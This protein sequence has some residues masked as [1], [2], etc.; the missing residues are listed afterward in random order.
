ML[1]RSC[2]SENESGTRFCVQCA[3]PLPRACGR[4]RAPLPDDARFCPR[5]GHLVEEAAPAGES[6]VD[7]DGDSPLASGALAMERRQLTVLFCD[8]V[9]A[10]ELASRLDPED[11]REVVRAYHE[12]C[13]KVVA[14]FQ[15][16]IA[17]YL[18]DGL[19]VYFGYPQAHED[20]AV[21]AVHAALGFIGTLK[22]LNAR[23]QREWSVTLALRIGVH[24][25]TVVVG[26]MGGRDQ[27]ESLALGDT[28]NLA[29]RLQEVADAGSVVISGATGQLVQE[30]FDL[31][32]LGDHALK[33]VARSLPLFRVMRAHPVEG[34]IDVPHPSKSTPL[35][36]REQEIGLL[37][38]GWEQAAESH[39]NALLLSGEAGMGKSRL[40]Q[41]LR[42]RIADEPHL[43]FAARCSAYHQN[44]A[45]HS[46]IDLVQ[47]ASDFAP[48]DT[49]EEKLSK[50][51]RVLVPMDAIPLMASLLSIPL[52]S[53]YPPITLSPDAQRRKTL[54]ALVE[55][56]LALSEQQ[57]VVLVVEDLQ[58]SDPS[59]IEFLGMLLEQLPTAAL[60]TVL[61]FRREF[62]SPWLRRS[63]VMQ[64]SL[65]PLTR[66][67]TAKMVGAITGGKALPAEVLGQVVGKTDGVPLFVE[68]LTK[69]VVES[70]LVEERA[71][72]FELSGALPELA[73]PSTLK[74]SLMARLDRASPTKEVVQLGAVLGR[75]F[76]YEI[77]RA[78]SSG[79]EA[80]LR[81]DLMRLERAELILR[82]GVPPHSSYVFKHALIQETA[83]QSL[84]KSTRVEYHGRIA[85]LLEKHF[86]EIVA[87]L[88]EVVANHFAEAGLTDR[89]I[90]Y[91]HRAAERAMDRSAE[92]ET[93]RHLTR[94]VELSQTLPETKERKERELVLQ[95]ALGV[96]SMADKGAGH[97]DVERVFS[98]V[99]DLCRTLGDLPEV[100]HALFGLSVFHQAR[101]ELDIA[102]RL[103]EKLHGLAEV[104]RDVS[105]FVSAH[106]SLGIPLFWWS[107]PVRALAH[108]EQAIAL[109]D[110]A[111]HRSLAYA[112]GQDPGVSARSYAALALWQVGFP[113]RALAMAH[114]AIEIARDDLSL[115]FA[116]CFAAILHWLRRERD[117]VAALVAE[118]VSMSESESFALWL[119]AGTVLR[120]WARV[121]SG[122]ES[123]GLEELQKGMAML[124]ETG[125]TV[126]SPLVLLVL[127]DAQR[128]V[129]RDDDAL[130][131]LDAAFA[132]APRGRRSFLGAELHRA[133]GELL[134]RRDGGRSDRAEREF[135]EAIE[136]ARIE[137][138]KR[139]ARRTPARPCRRSTSSSTRASRPST[140]G[141]LGICSSS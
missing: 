139:G 82:R 66:R 109:H 122:A 115:V 38:D 111:L 20:D 72:R 5:C 90:A 59:T 133:R 49:V 47:R 76:S 22:A 12:S 55:W 9:D 65:H 132:M 140:F 54:E 18:G 119:G 44:S 105:T 68:E 10:T 3:S 25:G 102:F 58:W 31:E 124:F 94:G 28:I 29:S 78:L 64:L 103:G 71:D 53:R 26:D 97:P 100:S 92:A 135:R 81:D 121:A 43:W 106:L 8:L 36:D 83:Y 21:R 23:L 77:L 2:G 101:G 7:T 79:T 6:A 129:G 14:V 89:A 131:T 34:D 80:A 13:E 96:Y 116:R 32:E 51:E 4:C 16:H 70:G 37:L 112:Y 62:E 88:P 117:Q 87:R 56:L 75:E 95:V 134:R 69:T 57:L 33:G 126:A 24:T 141:T 113:N 137:G 35:V 127:A 27:R 85:Q 11:W 110:P 19:L 136:L 130:G 120:G 99:R 108:F 123:E 104:S 1:C 61:T 15:G 107:H 67:Q 41:E 128:T 46:V 114:D 50:L 39:G 48:D 30:A 42:D 45:F 74:D 98:R 17:Q 86:P 84:L 52:P 63:H 60:L 91:Y 125:T 138:A 118:V 73:I 40:V 93:I